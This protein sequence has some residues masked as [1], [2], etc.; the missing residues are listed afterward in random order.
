MMDKDYSLRVPGRPEERKASK[1]MSIL[2]LSSEG[3]RFG[4]AFLE[5]HGRRSAGRQ[6]SEIW[7]LF[8]LFMI[9][10]IIRNQEVHWLVPVTCP[11]T[12][13][14]SSKLRTLS[15]D[16]RSRRLETSPTRTSLKAL[17]NFRHR[18]GSESEVHSQVTVIAGSYLAPTEKID[19]I[20]V[21]FRWCSLFDS[22]DVALHWQVHISLRPCQLSV[23]CVNRTPWWV[24][25]DLRLICI[26]NKLEGPDDFP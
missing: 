21:S 22:R 5:V 26:K 23:V 15:S 9:I 12:C 1:Y 17:P 11:T 7:V 25:F 13:P 8:T 24:L 19:D 18:D 16:T 4:V 20:F 2:W 10:R 3:I 6:R 14:T